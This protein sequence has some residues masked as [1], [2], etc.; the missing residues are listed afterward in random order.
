MQSPSPETTAAGHTAPGPKESLPA[1]VSFFQGALGSVR[2]WWA[3]GLGC[4]GI[5]SLSERHY[6]NPDGLS[7]LDLASEALH[8]GP[9]GLL[10]GLWSPG[11]PALLSLALALFHPAPRQE[12]PLVQFVNFFIFVLNLWAFHF[13]LRH[14]LSYADTFRPT[15]DQ[16]NRD[17]VP[18][19]FCTF[20]LFTLQDG[21]L[22]AVNPDLCMA[23][24]VFLVAG[25][26]C[27]LSLPGSGRKHYAAFGFVLGL[28]Y[29]VKA[30]MFPLGLILLGGLLLY[31][32]SH[33]VSRQ[34][35]L[36]SLSV[37]LLTA[38]PLVTLL[39]VRAGHLSLG[40][41]GKLNYA[42]H[43]NGLQLYAGWTGSD[44]AQT[45]PLS[46]YGLVPYAASKSGSPHLY[47]SPEHP[48]RRLM[49]T[50]LILEFSS[51]I[52]GTFPL[53]YDPSYWY[54]G[55]KARF[56]LRQQ[57]AALK[58]TLLVYKE[59][60]FNSSKT[61]FLV[62]AIILCIL[63]PRKAGFSNVL[64]ASW[65]VTWPLTALLMYAFV[66]VERR[67]TAVFFVILWL[68]IYGALMARMN[69][70]AAVAV[71][72]TVAGTMMIPFMVGM[73]DLSVHTVKDLVRSTPPDYEIAALGLRSLGVQSGD[74][75]A[76][77]GFPFDPFYA[78]YGGQRVV[79]T[80]AATDEFWTLSA[81]ELKS[82][83]ERLTQIGIKA[84]VAQD[85]PSK[86][87]LA[88][89]RDVKISESRRFSVLMLSEPLTKDPP[90]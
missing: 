11:Y 69:R 48:P 8:S 59:N 3:I 51:P 78:R 60:L 26:T 29:Y 86:S 37:F 44:R 70:Q 22:R 17:I 50:P 24:V 73:A 46:P 30:P 75:L 68:A 6:I 80:I 64:R 87:S 63:A 52:N 74:R 38:A 32:P 83:A 77:V 84:V 54:A 62:G 28:G 81:P 31:P 71:C 39:S 13:F 79:A 45:L 67:Y 53:W 42:W 34:R 27:R 23:A 65:L 88:N 76:V 25:I 47:G 58:V 5:L 43:V 40:E 12:F 2:F 16:G 57:I 49:E 7:Y 61:G 4:A 36:L 72:A 56:N 89:W 10:N 85:R 90:K 15:N 9:S 66:H 35:L 1:F 20:L 21:G 19:A 82:V 18:F 55:A 41:A 33:R 14:W